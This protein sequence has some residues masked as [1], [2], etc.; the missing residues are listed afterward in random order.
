MK[1][2]RCR[3]IV[4]YTHLQKHNYPGYSSLLEI[5][6][7]KKIDVMKRLNGVY[8]KSKMDKALNIMANMKNFSCEI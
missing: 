2:C 5:F 6:F 8:K 3:V 1:G 4:I 7:C